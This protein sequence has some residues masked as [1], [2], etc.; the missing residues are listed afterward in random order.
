MISPEKEIVQFIKEINVNEGDKKGHVEIWLKEI[1]IEMKN[2][3]A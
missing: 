2:T 1:E 3:L